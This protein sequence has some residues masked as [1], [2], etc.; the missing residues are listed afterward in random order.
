MPK[1]IT[2]TFYKMKRMWI[3]ANLP[4]FITAKD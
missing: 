4:A 1:I 2:Q 3:Q